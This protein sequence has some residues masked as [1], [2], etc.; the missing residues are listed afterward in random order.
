MVL[1]HRRSIETLVAMT[2]G[3]PVLVT[4]CAAALLCAG[5]SAQVLQTTDACRSQIPE[6][7]AKA[8]TSTYPK[9]RLPLVTDN[10]AEDVQERRLSGN[11]ACFGVATG[12]FN[13][14]TTK[15]I[16]FIAAQATEP[17]KAVV[18]VA[19]QKRD[20]W[21][22]S[23]LLSLPTRSRMFVSAAKAGKYVHTD[24][25]APAPNTGDLS[26]LTCKHAAVVIGLVEASE[27]IYCLVG[28]TWSH[29][30]VVD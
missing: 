18:I 1:C 14:D 17:S 6:T 25:Y 26:A 28:N 29:T 3:F 4:I 5:A 12:D 16:A 7:L 20:G 19:F 13:G 9:Y 15:D 27:D 23:R 10:L 21:E 8:F 2:R 11:N 24:S 22:F 30:N